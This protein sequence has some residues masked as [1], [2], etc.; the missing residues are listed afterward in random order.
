MFELLLSEIIVSEANSPSFSDEW[1]A[2]Q[3]GCGELVMLLAGRMKS[4]AAGQI[5]KLTALDHGAHEDIPAWCRMTGHT[6]V[7]SA[8]PIYFI[9][10]RK[11]KREQ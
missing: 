3:M 11:D 7:S 10:R 9:E 6:L 1:D 5:L 8:H 4:L 2:G